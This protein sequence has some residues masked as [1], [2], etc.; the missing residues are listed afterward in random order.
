VRSYSPAN[1]S[2]DVREPHSRGEAFAGNIADRE[3][4]ITFEFD[5]AN[6]I[7]REMPHGKDLACELV[8]S[9]AAVSWSAKPSL[10]LRGFVNRAAE[11][12]V[13]ALDFGEVIFEHTP[14]GPAAFWNSGN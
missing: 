14:A 10:Q 6:E 4:Q 11:I 9:G 7:T 12:V 13:L 5:D 3:N 2:E 8:R 1:G